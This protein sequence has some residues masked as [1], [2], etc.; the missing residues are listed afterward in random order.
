M[1]TDLIL[2]I[3]N[4]QLKASLIEKD[5]IKT[6]T[7]ALSAEIADNTRITNAQAFAVLLSSELKELTN[8]PLSKFKI[9]FVAEPEDVFLGFV[10]A[11]KHHANLDDF[12]VS[13]IKDKI[14]DV[15]LDECY[16]SYEKLAPFVYQ[17]I[18]VKQDYLEN[19]LKVSDETGAGLGSVIP[20]PLLL[21]RFVSSANPAIFVVTE[22]DAKFVV[23]SELQGVF[24]TG[25]F[26]SEMNS[27]ELNKLVNEL[28]FYRREKPIKK[29]YTIGG[30]EEKMEGDYE[31]EGLNLPGSHGE[32]VEKEYG[33]NLLCHY[34]LDFNEKFSSQ[35]LNLLSLLPLPVVEKKNVALI[36]VGA[37]AALAVTALLLFVGFKFGPSFFANRGSSNEVLSEATQAVE[38][39]SSKEV[40]TPKQE[41]NKKELVVR[42]EN[43]SN[44]N[45][46]A[47]RTKELLAE[48][49]Y[50]IDSIDTSDE[51]KKDTVL[52][53]KPEFEKYKDL[54]VE[55]LK[56][57]FPNIVVES[58]L[59][60]TESY[61]V[62]ILAGASS[63]L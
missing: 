21:S 14:K 28:S 53:F 5:G 10:G 36:G 6:L 40:E 22:A 37:S 58:S 7:K 2:S 39:T 57:S 43:A 45:G 34:Y 20:W 44:I 17:Y 46:L 47:A 1:P 26:G 62:L 49:G 50:T 56:E 24:F 3:R 25:V 32:D 29:V 60:E 19:L 41:L 59:D 55:D 63:T 38:T 54:L 42:V 9:N 23:L 4:N 12:I 27:L 18:A 61:G 13:E 51:E 8:T 35:Q 33:I 52:R 30:M 11:N 48:A 31:V 15:L 16:F